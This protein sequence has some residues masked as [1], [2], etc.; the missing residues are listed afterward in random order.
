[1]VAHYCNAV[2]VHTVVWDYNVVSHETIVHYTMVVVETVAQDYTVV[3]VETV[4][5]DYTVV[6]AHY[7]T[8]VF[9]Q[10]VP[11]YVHLAPCIYLKSSL[12]SSPKFC[13][14]CLCVQL[15]CKN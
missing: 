15:T 5:Q 9:T 12:S 3:V 6:V 7:Y 4:A 2:V 11:L 8:A 10:F 1:V 14:P 13:S